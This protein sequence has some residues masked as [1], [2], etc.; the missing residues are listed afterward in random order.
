[1]LKIGVTGGIGSGKTT[2]CKIFEVLGVPVYYADIEA[3]A[4]MESDNSLVEKIKEIFGNEIYSSEGKLNRKKLSDIVFENKQKLAQLNALV[5]P[6]VI[7]H[8]QH[9]FHSQKTPY[10]I[11][12]AALLFESGSYQ[13][14]DK[15]ITVYAPKEIRIKRVT[16]RDNV[17]SSEVEARME[18]QM[19][20]EE[21]RKKSDYVIMNNEE[22][23]VLPQV[24][25]IH[26]Q[27]LNL[28]EKNSKD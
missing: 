4:L 21:K 2:I 20:E 28:A 19:P 15:I 1:M 22:E 25:K 7:S 17:S 3:K 26:R 11:K 24:L 13:N 16:E 27:L 14:L 5:H 18:N 12:E 23:L 8:G 6:A 9:W 10:V